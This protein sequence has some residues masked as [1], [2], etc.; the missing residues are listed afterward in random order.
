MR[1]AQAMT[2]L[3][4][5]D[6]VFLTG[7]PGSGKS[8]VLR[9]F[10]R[11]ATRSGKTVAVTASTGIAATQIG[12]LTIHSWSGIG[13][14][15]LLRQHDLELLTSKDRLVH[16]YLTTDVLIIDE[17]SMLS[18]NF[19]SMLD[20]L[21]RTI[22][23]VDAPFGGLQ[24]ILAGDMFQL[25]PIN[26][27]STESDFAFHSAAW[28]DLD[29]LPCYLTEQYR[30]SDDKLAE[31]LTAMRDGSFGVTHEAILS[32]R[33]G[34]EPLSGFEPTRL[35]SH[36]VDVDAMNARRLADI[37][38]A[39]HTYAMELRGPRAL[40]EPLQRGVLAPQELILK[41]GAEVMFVANDQNQRYANG[42]LGRVVDLSGAWPVVQLTSSQRKIPVEP[43]SWVVE[44]DGVNKA[45]IRQV[46]LR[47]AWAITVHK[48][49]GMSLDAAEI[50]L[51][52]SFTPGMGY[53]ALSRLRSLNGLYLKGLNAMALQL[54]PAIFDFDVS[55]RQRSEQ[56]AR[57][58]QDSQVGNASPP[59]GPDET[60]LDPK[61]LDKLKAWRRDQARSEGVPAY[62]IA[63][64]IMLAEIAMRSPR[65][66]FE[67]RRIKGMGATRV[68]RYGDAILRIVIDHLEPSPTQN[69]LF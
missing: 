32:G 12:G 34:V 60:D 10:I 9:Q 67:L 23:D 19:L 52:R 7:A 25:P 28:H 62:V 27:D 68:Q 50:D 51:S 33:I 39:P 65:N 42:T 56:L 36:N 49:Q 26:R 54:H 13:I 41:V 21:A 24:M 61:L 46:P 53:V 63:H 40:V 16:R 58:T 64:D 3:L 6:S 47:L 2:R 5:G 14:R 11:V 15:D 43:H 37:A 18:G 8:Y 1:Q 29:P 59:S 31:V 69:S 48:S 17:V 66:T 38:S 20:R 30:Q 44:E 55:I 45:E 22:R 35:Y 57:L 4:A